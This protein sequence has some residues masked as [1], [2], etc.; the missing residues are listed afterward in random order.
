MNPIDHPNGGKTHGGTQPKT[1]WGKW[2]KW[3]STRKNK[4]KS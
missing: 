2:A 1:K 3:V 4:K